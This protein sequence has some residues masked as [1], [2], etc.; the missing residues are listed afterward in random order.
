MVLAV[1]GDR[2]VVR[3]RGLLN[4]GE[5]V[6][7]AGEP[8]EATAEDLARFAIDGDR[9]AMCREFAPALGELIQAC[10]GS[11]EHRR[12]ESGVAPV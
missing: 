5:S 7:A 6:A 11:R 12:T 8:A 3:G 10:D 2:H 4:S 9:L 1:H